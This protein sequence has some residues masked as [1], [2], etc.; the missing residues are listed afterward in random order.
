MYR[1]WWFPERNPRQQRVR[2]EMLAIVFQVF[3]KYNY[4]HI[5]T[6]A[7]ESVEILK[8]GGDIIDQQVYGL[9]GLAQWPSD[10]KDYALH[11]DL[12][13]PLA[14]YV[15]DHTQDIVF[16]FSR[17]QAQPV[18]RWESHK[19]LRYKEFRQCDIDTIWRSETSVWQR[20]DAQSIIVMESA[21]GAVCNNFSLNINFIAKVSHLLLT[22][23]YLSSL[24]I[25]WDLQVATL[26][27]L[28]NYFKQA[29]DVFSTKLIGLV[30]QE[31][32]KTIL[33][34]IETKDHTK[35][36]H[37]PLYPELDYIICA[38][39]SAWVKFEYDICIVRGQNYYSGMVV[40]WM[41]KDDIALWSL[42]AGW[43]YDNLTN[44]IDPKQS[45]SWVWTSL[46]RFT[47]LVM[48]KVAEVKN[49]E[50]YLFVNFDNITDLLLLSKSDYFI[51]KT[52]EFYPVNAKLSKQFE[53]AE[54][55]S[56]PFV[57]LYGETEKMGWYF[58]VKDLQSWEQKKIML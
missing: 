12:T 45:F 18:R 46:W 33:E 34:I 42:A 30:W 56:I 24:W 28:D 49:R 50:S 16:P 51:S 25:L 43:R 22:K 4:Q 10:T 35:L 52:V 2:D 19:R 13:V 31:K 9:Y 53:F 27:L 5:R 29:H 36:S 14:R 20:Y 26:K 41:D 48:E 21:M 55:K 8:K 1:P 3:E 17:Y 44:F 23:S 38:L 58:I 15:L 32:A 39:K 54:K 47:S 37:L 6:P 40:E 57:V 7:V 11:F